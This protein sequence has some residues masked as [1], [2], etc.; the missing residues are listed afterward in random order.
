MIYKN[1]VFIFIIVIII[2]IGIFLREYYFEI[3]EFS[4]ISKSVLSE[5]SRSRKIQENRKWEIFVVSSTEE[6]KLVQEQYYRLVK[7][8]FW[9]FDFK[10]NFIADEIEKEWIQIDQKL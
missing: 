6:W 8:K 4:E 9:D 2:S 1:Y 7:H 3:S 10:L 5:K